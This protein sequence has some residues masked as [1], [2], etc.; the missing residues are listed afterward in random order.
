MFFS[1]HIFTILS[2]S[3]TIWTSGTRGDGNAKGF[4]ALPS[5]GLDTD[6]NI[7]EAVVLDYNH[8]GDDDDDDDDGG[9]D[10]G[11][12][13][14]SSAL[15]NWNNVNQGKSGWW[16]AVFGCQQSIVER[17]S[18]T[19]DDDDDDDDDDGYDNDDDDDRSMNADD[20]SGHDDDIIIIWIIDDDKQKAL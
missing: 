13:G 5:R 9:G 17:S 14:G 8:D 16:Q 15:W 3:W 10:D 11:D 12:D 20:D 7:E 6:P 2:Q 1:L 19:T 18:L 4:R